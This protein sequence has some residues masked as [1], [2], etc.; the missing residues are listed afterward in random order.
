[1]AERKKRGTP[2]HARAKRLTTKD[3]LAYFMKSYRAADGLWFVKTE[4]KR[5]FKEALAR[6]NEVWKVMPKIQA[7]AVKKLLGARASF[8]GLAECFPEKLRVEGFSFSTVEEKTRF[9]CIVRKCPWHDLMRSSGREN[10]SDRVHSLICL[11][12]CRGWAV[13]FGDTISARIGTR[14]CK[15]DAACELIFETEK[16]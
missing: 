14:I 12:D 13:E 5:G 10:L 6:D 1:M 8:K 4:E 16:Q 3:A 15:G 9:S 11:T 2:V 7:R